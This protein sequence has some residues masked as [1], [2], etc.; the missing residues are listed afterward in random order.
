MSDNKTKP[1]NLIEVKKFEEN[2]KALENKTPDELYDILID[3]I[4]MYHPS[5]DISMIEKAYNVA[6]E[7]HGDQKRKSGEYPEG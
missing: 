6:N 5:D 1:K 7:C 4:K 2:S 3:T